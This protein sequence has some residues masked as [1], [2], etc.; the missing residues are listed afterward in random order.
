MAT[1]AEIEAVKAQ[2]R[3]FAR[4]DLLFYVQNSMNNYRIAPCHE[5]ICERLMRFESD[6]KAGRSPRL[7]VFLP[8]RAG[9]SFIAAE[10]FPAWFIA[11]N[12]AL[13]VIAS[14]YGYDLASDFTTHS[15][16]LTLGEYHR[17]VFPDAK[18][19]PSVQRSNQWETTAG[20]GYYG[21][22]VGGALTGK[23]ADILII[24][25]PMKNWADALSQTKRNA[26]WDW[27]TTTAYTR[28]MPGGG[29][30]LIMTRWHPD[31]LG[32]RI[33]DKGGFDVV[34]YP[35]IDDSGNSYDPVRWPIKALE[36][37]RDT[38]GPT[39]WQCLYMQEPTNAEGQIFKR[40]MFNFH[41]EAP[42]GLSRICISVDAAFKGGDGSDYVSVQAWGEKERSYYLLDNDT[43]RMGF[44]DSLRA[45]IDMANRHSKHNPTIIIEDKA[46]GPAIIETIKKQYSRVVGIN[47]EGGKIA[48]AQAV[49]PLYEG[50]R[51]SFPSGAPWL[52]CF[53]NELADFP[54]SKHDDAVDAMTQAL[55]Y[56]ENHGQQQAL[57]YGRLNF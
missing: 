8:P 54:T 46:N 56:L 4:R 6:I 33:L 48:R 47:P 36:E 53:I 37:I 49:V 27:Y 26:I 57:Q 52:D 51:V 22:G 1:T 39:A 30:L 44:S 29:V 17:S 7:A 32:G 24:D 25:D 45:I 35:A 2:A 42:A 41:P 43:R 18:L 15:R 16:D 21:V 5:D 11:R 12:P 3:A 50:Q 13:N 38:I 10:R 14:S 20:G 31:D 28:L 23:G 19:S 55:T 34:K 9:K 40:S